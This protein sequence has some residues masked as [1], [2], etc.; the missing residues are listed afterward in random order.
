MSKPKFKECD[1]LPEDS[2]EDLNYYAD[3]VEK[4]A[5]LD[6]EGVFPNRSNKHASIVMSKMTEK[7]VRSIK[8]FD[9]NLSGDILVSCFEGMLWK[10]LKKTLE[11]DI[12]IDFIIEDN[13]INPE[14]KSILENDKVNV[15]LTS[16][17]FINELEVEKITGYFAVFDEKM[18]RV[19][20]N[21]KDSREAFCS[22]N[23]PRIAKKILAILSKNNHLLSKI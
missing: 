21:R 13:L 8:I 10:E 3:Q 22:F 14:V 18:F 5:K 2:A 11:R 16:P 12:F 9:K 15:F 6:S 1:S 20:K 4:L 7:A 23:E 19:Q 17:E